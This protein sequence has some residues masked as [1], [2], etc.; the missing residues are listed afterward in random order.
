MKALGCLTAMVF[1]FGCQE[2]KKD[3]GPNAGT[4]RPA[5]NDIYI[6]SMNDPANLTTLE[7]FGTTAVE[8]GRSFDKTKPSGLSWSIKGSNL[9]L[10]GDTYSL[11]YDQKNH[12]WNVLDENG[13]IRGN[14]K[15]LRTETCSTVSQIEMVMF[16]LAEEAR[17]NI[18][19]VAL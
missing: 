10:D 19:Y 8:I 17:A 5:E 6:A 3:S 4:C 2:N 18:W 1:V 14:L 11:A 7:N 13:G 12:F 16:M 9:I 15:P